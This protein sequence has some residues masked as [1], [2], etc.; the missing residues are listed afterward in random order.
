MLDLIENSNETLVEY[1]K[2][3]TIDEFTLLTNNLYQSIFSKK[4]MIRINSKPCHP[5]LSQT[6]RLS[7][8]SETRQTLSVN[9]RLSGSSETRQDKILDEDNDVSNDENDDDVSDDENNYEYVTCDWYDKFHQLFIVNI[10]QINNDLKSSF[11]K[12]L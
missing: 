12:K 11:Y 10:C 8:S 9:G 6:G 1:S 4:I 3:H 5:T 2:N 7:G